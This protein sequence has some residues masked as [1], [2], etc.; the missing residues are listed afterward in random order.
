MNIYDSWLAKQKIA[1]RGLHDETS[2][3]NTLSAFEKAIK[4]GYAI[5][6]DLHMTAD[7]MVVVF[8]DENMKRL[9]GLDA[10]IREVPYSQIKDLTIL[11]SEEKIPLFK[12][13]LN[14]IKGRQPLLIEIKDHKNIGVME[15]KVADILKD[16]K[17]EFA[18][19][20]FNPF[21]VKWFAD[22]TPQYI[23]GQL[24]SCFKD[25]D[26]AWWKKFMLK[27]L[28]FIKSN[29]SQFVSYDAEDIAR[30]QI[31]RVKKR[32]PIIAWTVR[33]EQEAKKVSRYCDNIIFENYIPH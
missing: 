27:N 6:T 2:P 10:D 18:L 7:G 28:F 30:P 11:N 26:L 25:A 12:D 1:H 33:S 17:G 32:M 3:E 19:Q 29:K 24:S 23:R 16:Y 20:S 9:T 13:F 4:G 15:Q 8:H 22:N 5:E 14:F 21:I 31:L